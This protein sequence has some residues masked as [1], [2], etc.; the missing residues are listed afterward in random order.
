M[1]SFIEEFDIEVKENN[2][3]VSDYDAFDDV[4][5]IGQV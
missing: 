3:N 4:R 1:R 5:V 2:S